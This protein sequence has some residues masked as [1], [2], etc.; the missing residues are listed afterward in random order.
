MLGIVIG[1][2]PA[3]TLWMA[4]DMASVDILLIKV[5]AGRLGQVVFYPRAVGYAIVTIAHPGRC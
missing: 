4:D 5:H 1:L 2:L 3:N